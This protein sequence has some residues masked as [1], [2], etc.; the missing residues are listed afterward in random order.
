MLEAVQE[1]WRQSVR[2]AALGCAQH[3]F[4]NCRRDED[5]ARH[6]WY[7]RELQ[8]KLRVVTVEGGTADTF[9]VGPPPVVEKPTFETREM[10]GIVGVEQTEKL[11]ACVQ[12]TVL[13]R[14]QGAK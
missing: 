11:D 3:Q 5:S 7:H 1:R 4:N 13:E 12:V 2:R 10:V 6:D 8:V 9:L 14:R